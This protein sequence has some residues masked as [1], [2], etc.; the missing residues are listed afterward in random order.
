MARR[1]AT[2]QRRPADLTPAQMKAA[3]PRLESRVHELQE[4]DPKSITSGDAP[5]VQ[6]LE[7]RIKSTLSQIYGEDTHEFARLKEA[8]DLDLTS[9]ILAISPFGDVPGT[10]VQEIQEGVE[11]GR[12]RAIALLQA[13]IDSCGNRL[14]TCRRLPPTRCHPVR[15]RIRV[16]L[17]YS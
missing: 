5:Q 1:S 3:V 12:Q 7:A 6:A 16:R 10:S 2:P 13:E 17:T 4:F 14:N 8:A 9:Y 11:R 15:R